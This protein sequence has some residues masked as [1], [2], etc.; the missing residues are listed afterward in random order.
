MKTVRF[1][2]NDDEYELIRNFAA[3][4]NL[5]LSEA[6]RKTMIEAIEDEFDR[7]AYETAIKEAE[8]HSK[9]YT[10]DE[11]ENELNLKS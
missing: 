7:N 4:K 3:R 8:Y 10:L 9:R 2:V 1:E 11:V 5:S 6:V